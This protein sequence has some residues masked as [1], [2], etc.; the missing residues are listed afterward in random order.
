VPVARLA[1]ACSPQL[2]LTFPPL[3]LQVLVQVVT[4]LVPVCALGFH[5]HGMAPSDAA[6]STRLVVAICGLG[7]FALLLGEAAAYR[8]L[9]SPLSL[10][11]LHF[12]CI[13][14]VLAGHP[15]A[16]PGAN[17]QIRGCMPSM[18]HCM[19]RAHGWHAPGP[20]LCT[21]CPAQVAC[22]C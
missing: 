4:W 21:S 5:A 15:A 7:I 9:A 18:E 1:P 3:Y 17:P 13:T 6:T 19:M 2:P 20:M 8:L 22:S 11:R 10:A 12:V 16:M 14:R